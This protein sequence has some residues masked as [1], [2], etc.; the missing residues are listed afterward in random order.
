MSKFLKKFEENVSIITYIILIV[1]TFS[2]VIGRYLL[3]SSISY[4]EEIA[5]NLFVLLSVI[6]TAMA[7]RDRAHLGLSAFTELMPKRTQLFVSGISNIF[8]MLFGLVLFVT[9][10]MMVKN[11]IEINAKTITLMWPAWIFGSFLP[12]G[13][14]FI[15]YRFLEAAIIDFK[16]FKA[17]EGEKK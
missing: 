1:I 7:T 17:M 2:N 9:G 14:L 8:G 16:K 13:A 15:I 4:T 12:F 10:I 11:Q 5:V 3:K 6:G